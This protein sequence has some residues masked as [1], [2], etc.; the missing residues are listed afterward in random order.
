[1][2]RNGWI[3][4]QPVGTPVEELPLRPGTVNVLR[5]GGVPTIGRLRAMGDHELPGLRRFGP[6]ALADVR[7][8]PPPTGR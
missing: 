6:C 7:F 3:A 1:M 5:A 4:R 2:T 8:L